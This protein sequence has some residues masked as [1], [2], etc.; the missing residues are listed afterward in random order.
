MPEEKKINDDIP[1]PLIYEIK[2]TDFEEDNEVDY[3]EGIFNLNDNVFYI[4][5]FFFNR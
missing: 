2:L 3:E 5:S 4:S 1:S